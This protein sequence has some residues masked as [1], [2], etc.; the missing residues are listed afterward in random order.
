MFLWVK[1]APLAWL[2]RPSLPPSTSPS[3]AM[4]PSAQPCPTGQC[5]SRPGLDPGP[6]LSPLECS[7]PQCLAASSSV[8]SLSLDLCSSDAPLGCP[9]WVGVPR[10]TRK[11]C[12]FQPYRPGSQLSSSPPPPASVLPPR[13]LHHLPGA[14]VLQG[15]G[16]LVSSVRTVLRHLH[17][18]ANGR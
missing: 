5:A 2:T 6:L 13:T 14:L 16:L 15:S 12:L 8:F 4:G 9:C 3:I 10:A 11:H 7:S 18:A 17:L 1:P